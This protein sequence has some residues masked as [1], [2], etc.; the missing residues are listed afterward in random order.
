MKSRTFFTLVFIFLVSKDVF[1]VKRL[2]LMIF[3]LIR[4]LRIAG[5]RL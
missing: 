2:L 3:L 1:R 5:L 4:K